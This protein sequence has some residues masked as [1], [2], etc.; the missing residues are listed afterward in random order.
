MMK[1]SLAPDIVLQVAKVEKNTL[2]RW[3]RAAYPVEY[4]NAR[5]RQRFANQHTVLK[6]QTALDSFLE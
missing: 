1:S 3:L 5:P 4:A 6:H 2:R